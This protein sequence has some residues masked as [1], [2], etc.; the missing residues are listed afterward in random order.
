[1]NNKVDLTISLEELST[2]QGITF[3]HWNS[4][5]LFPKFENVDNLLKSANLE[6]LLIS[7]TWLSENTPTDMVAVDG[8]NLFRHDRDVEV[9]KQR[10]GGV[11]LYCKE[12]FNIVQ[13]NNMCVSDRDIEILTS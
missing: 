11:G 5:S 1:M 12:R 13:M 7:E 3:G 6:F 9:C 8:Y 2:N 10:G 4:R